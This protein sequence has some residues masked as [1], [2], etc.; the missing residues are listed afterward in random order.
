MKSFNILDKYDQMR[1]FYFIRDNAPIHKQIE[2]IFNKRNG[3]YKCVFLPP[4]SPELNPI[5]KFWALVKRKVRRE[6][7]Q[8][9]ET[10]Q[11][12]IVDAA[13]EVT[14]KHL[15]NIIQHSKT[16]FDNCLNYIPI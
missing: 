14:I 15:Q 11:D 2:D 6:K 3:D 8:D 16:Q 12:R 5:E 9:T 13:N 1:G 7:L 10:L 4:Y